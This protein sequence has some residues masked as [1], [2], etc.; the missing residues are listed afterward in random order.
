MVD[1]KPSLI[2]GDVN[3]TVDSTVPVS[4]EGISLTEYRNQGAV[5]NLAATT[6]TTIVT[7]AFVSGTFQN[8]VMV[9]C[10]G[11]DYAKFFLTINAVDVDVRRTGPDRNLTFD[12]TG[13]PLKLVAGDVVDVKVE[14]FNSGDLLDFDATIYGY[15]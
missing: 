11:Q 7:Q 14:H 9:S 12:F 2:T 5:T 8:L 15:D 13:A 6:K 4:V 3:A 10:S 1:F